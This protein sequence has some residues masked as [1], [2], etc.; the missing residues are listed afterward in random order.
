[1]I[2]N[3]CVSQALLDKSAVLASAAPDQLTSVIR[4]LCAVTDPAKVFV[5]PIAVVYK[6]I[7]I[8]FVSIGWP[9]CRVCSSSY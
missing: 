6:I 4:P 1:M 9:V 7:D 8:L 3:W 5:R 2:F